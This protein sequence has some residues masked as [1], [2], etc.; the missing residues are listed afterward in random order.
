[1]YLH[2]KS[3][4]QKTEI[5]RFYEMQHVTIGRYIALARDNLAINQC[6]ASNMLNSHVT[7][8]LLVHNSGAFAAVRTCVHIVRDIL[9]LIWVPAAYFC[10]SSR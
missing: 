2:D 6:V 8:C 4:R 10:G 9:A 5:D 1:V 7:L 3:P